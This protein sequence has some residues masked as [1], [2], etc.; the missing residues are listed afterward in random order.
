[1]ILGL[2]LC[3][4]SSS[5]LAFDVTI[6]P[7]AARQFATLPHDLSFPEGITANPGTG[8]IFVGNFDF[9]GPNAIVKFDR[10]GR[11][12]ARQEFGAGTPL[13]G[14]AFNTADDKVY[15]ANFGA[16]QIQRV[17][18]ALGPNNPVEVVATLPAIGAPGPRVEGNA[19]GS[20]DTV[21]FGS[22][23]VPA[24]NA[25]VFAGDDTLYVSDSF[26]GAIYSIANVSTCAA[27]CTV[28]TL[29]QDPLLATPGF[30]PFG[31]N[32]LAL[33]GD[34]Q[35][36][37][38]ANT[39][40]DRVLQVDLGTAAVSIFAESVHGA[41]GLA[42][43]N[44][45]LYV[46]AN[47]ADQIVGLDGSGRVVAELGEHRGFWPNGKLEG[48]LFPA[49]LTR[50]GRQLY[51]TNLALPLTGAVGDEP[52]EDVQEYSVSVITLF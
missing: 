24:P 50:V 30:P 47:Q 7:F 3:S 41:D 39:G 40:D 33:S 5:A 26:Q 43:V 20:Q 38:V 52:E 8:D 21:T 12:V 9:V 29:I 42:M 28:T 13:L 25:M 14:L 31:A 4:V 48:L 18:T 44:G 1:M 49:S 51:V 10:R 27:P 46:A 19:D 36:L 16:S 23:R 11:Q 37:Y 22:N 17:S 45:T 34:E 15:V 6:R 32:G 2:L 35:T